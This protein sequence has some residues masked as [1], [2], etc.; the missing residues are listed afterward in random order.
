[1]VS[2]WIQIR[3][4]RTGFLDAGEGSSI[5]TLQSEQIFPKFNP[6]VFAAPA[7]CDVLATSIMYIG[8]NLTQA[9]SFQML[10]GAVIIFTGLFSVAFLGSYLQGAVI[11]FTGLFSVAFL[12][13]YL[14]GFRWFGMGLVTVGL[15]IVGV[16]DIIFDENP[17]DDINGII[18]D[19]S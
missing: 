5:S 19:G 18:T 15:V 11:I 9:S 14:Q 6:L 3:R 12:G 7:F 1:M 4:S 17:K 13:S 10:R 8:L 2:R 16:G